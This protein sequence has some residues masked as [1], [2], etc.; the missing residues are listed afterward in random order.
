MNKR[1]LT[2]L[3]N[4][5]PIAALLLTGFAARGQVSLAGRITDSKS[6]ARIA[7]A[8]VIIADL[9]IS[10]GSDSLGNYHLKD[11]P[12]GYYLIEV[13]RAGYATNIQ[14]ITITGPVKQDFE[15]VPS[16]IQLNEVVVTGVIGATAR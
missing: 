7:G 1:L 11:I 13:A 6:H 15:L 8:S 14:S 12:A 2:L 3:K 16:F 10:A 5:L 9:N 4:I